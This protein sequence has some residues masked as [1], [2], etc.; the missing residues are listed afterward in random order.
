MKHNVGDLV[1]A[2]EENGTYSVGY[3][4]AVELFGSLPRHAQYLYTVQWNGEVAGEPDVDDY[5]AEQI[6]IFK[7]VLEEYKARMVER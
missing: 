7:G 3:I 4:I 2:R 1:M 6:K 5:P